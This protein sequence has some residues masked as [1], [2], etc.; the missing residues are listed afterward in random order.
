M[1]L[2]FNGSYVNEQMF[3]SMVGSWWNK[4]KSSKKSSV[5]LD[6]EA[7][8]GDEVTEGTVPAVKLI[9]E[10]L[11]EIAKEFIVNEERRKCFGFT[12]S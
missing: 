11:M 10:S 6:C 7:N 8:G 2:C 9:N 4:L 3:L 1:W 12:R 5:E